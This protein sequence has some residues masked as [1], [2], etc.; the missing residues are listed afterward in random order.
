MIILLTELR[1]V[2]FSLNLHSLGAVTQFT[3]IISLVRLQPN[4][5]MYKQCY[6]LILTIIKKFYSCTWT[7]PPTAGVRQRSRFWSTL[8]SCNFL[9]FPK[10][11]KTSHKINTSDSLLKEDDLNC[12]TQHVLLRD[13]SYAQDCRYKVE[14][15]N[16]I[17]QRLLQ[18]E[19]SWE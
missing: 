10:V 16:K 8:I 12:N 18:I 9:S 11:S 14:T 3:C 17:F 4:W 2:Q 13:T 19:Q 6:Y 1:V 7:Y 5:T 15:N